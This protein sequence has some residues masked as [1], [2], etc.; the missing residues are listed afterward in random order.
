MPLSKKRYF[1]KHVMSQEVVAP[2]NKDQNSAIA[3]VQ[4]EYKKGRLSSYA[5]Q[6]L[7]RLYEVMEEAEKQTEGDLRKAQSQLKI[8][9]RKRIEYFNEVC[10]I[11]QRDTLFKKKEFESYERKKEKK[12][13]W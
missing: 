12:F 10:N 8:R 9:N 1:I 11:E 4:R 7:Y 13:S 2:K 3:Q 6:D 5:A